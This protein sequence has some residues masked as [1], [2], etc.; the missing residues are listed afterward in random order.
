MLASGTQ[1]G[2]YTIAAPLGAGGMGEVYRAHDSRLDRA[3]AIKVLPAHL[4][5][6]PEALARFVREAKAVAALSHPN[7][8]TIYD[9]GT[10]QG[11]SFAVMELLE[12][13]TLRSRVTRSALPSRKAIEIGAAVADGLAAA[14]AK[15]ITHRD[16]KP[17]NLFLTSDGRV[18]I[19]DFGLAKLSEP[20]AVAIG[21]ED[22]TRRA[23]TE[24][25]TI[26]GTAGYMSPEQVR[27]EMVD[28][29][30][31]IFSFGCVLYEMVT[32]ERAFAGRTA[33]EALAAILR[34][35][36]SELTESGKKLPGEL[37]LLITHCLE[38]SPA[39]RF[40]SAQDLSFALRAI[41][42][43]STIPG[44]ST[45]PNALTA[46]T[47]ISPSVS[48]HA[49]LRWRQVVWIAAVLTLLLFAGGLYS[50]IGGGETIDSLAVLPFVNVGADQNTEYL[51]D[52][53]TESLII[54]LAQLP[55]LRV[56]SRDSAFRYKGRDTDEQTVGRELGVR[57]VLKGRVVPRGNDLSISVELV[58]AREGNQLWGAQY[59][60]KLTDLLALQEE[61]AKEIAE[62][63]RLRLSGEE[64]KQ[65]AKRATDNP[66]AYQ[67]YIKG[68]FF[69]NQKTVDGY[70]RGR[71]FFQQAIDHD[72]TYARAHA[73]VADS[74]LA[75]GSYVIGA[76]PPREAW[77]AAEKAAR[78]AMSLDETLAEAH[79]SLGYVLTMYAWKWPEVEK[80]L[81][82]ALEL[83]PNYAQAHHVYAHYL[84]Y[85]GRKEEALEA[86]KRGLALDPLDLTLNAHL[87]WH[88]LY[89]GQNDQALDQ[90]LKTVEMNQNFPL[91]RWYL[92]LTYEQ[93][94][95]FTEAIAELNKLVV[96]SKRNPTYL[97]SLGHAYAMAGQRAEGA[98]ILD[99]LNEL[100]K[101]RYVLP[102]CFAVIYAGLGEKDQAFAY[103][104][105][106]YEER[107]SW[108]GHLK[109]EPRMNSL[110]SD[111]RF[112][113]LL[114]RVGLT[115]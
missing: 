77:V 106:A 44:L 18:K 89:A 79:T 80:E 93:K 27:G 78:Q 38:K 43:G 68:R 70:K 23:L 69:W 67:L 3:V 60:R 29:P 104:Q 52:G 13:E 58:D 97:A 90:L 114:R 107:D 17:E 112:T 50:F 12:G 5:Q 55:Q 45:T 115:P 91:A 71:E 109:V 99:E 16:L 65:L 46:A 48:A 74:T 100:S 101:Q 84:M 9:I 75:L 32:G 4:A 62:K 96:L 33:A 92:G 7:I 86:S 81:K 24:P 54:K 59:N 87:G 76:T 10:E 11:V 113:D 56:K 94:G 98:K 19:L 47:E 30:S 95:M 53:I 37:G 14:H 108:M 8:L 39:A 42:S 88:Y 6:D 21:S 15:G 85:Q 26:M 73:G 20:G 25:G 63:L 40:Q 61:M 82:R 34:D 36:P 57:A 41:P 66:E 1:L 31:D 51:S 83:D 102:Y 64:Q 2:P 49:R 22:A 72:P 105:K 110:R 35:E 111:P 28:A 103:L